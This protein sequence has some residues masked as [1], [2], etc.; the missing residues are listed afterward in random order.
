LYSVLVTAACTF[1]TLYNCPKVFGRK[2]YL[3]PSDHV[4][5]PASAIDAVPKGHLN[6]ATTVPNSMSAVVCH[7]PPPLRQ[8]NERIRL[9]LR[10]AVPSSKGN[11]PSASA[12]PHRGSP[13]TFVSDER[14]SRSTPLTLLRRQRRCVGSASVVLA[15][16]TQLFSA[17]RTPRYPQPHLQ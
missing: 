4:P 8:Q 15:G 5:A 6:E 17:L 12:P 11:I 1:G 3:L 10:D 13:E 7:D 9:W 2:T 16:S 14:T